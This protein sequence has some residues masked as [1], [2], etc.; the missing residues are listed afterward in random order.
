MPRIQPKTVANRLIAIHNLQMRAM[1]IE[2]ESEDRFNFVTEKAESA[3]RKLE[4]QADKLSE[5]TLQRLHEIG[6][7]ADPED[8]M[9][10]EEEERFSKT[11][12]A[13]TVFAHLELMG[14]E[15]AILHYI[16]DGSWC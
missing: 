15:P 5:A 6:I 16:G 14:S 3:A 4:R 12:F 8:G 11:E 1:R 9:S 10:I 13:K 2:Q 7:V